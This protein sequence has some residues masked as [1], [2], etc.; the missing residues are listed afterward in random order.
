MS[1]KTDQFRRYGLIAALLLTLGATWWA[2]GSDD[3]PAVD[4][5]QASAGAR[6]AQEAR[7]GTARAPAQRTPAV[8]LAFTAP[9][10]QEAG[11]GRPQG[12]APPQAPF[13]WTPVQREPWADARE[14]QFAA[15]S[16]PPPP[17]PPVVAKGPPPPPPPPVAP[18]FPYQVM[19]RLVDGV[20]A[21]VFLVSANRSIAVK[22][23]DVVD[24][25]WRVENISEQGA[26]KLLWLPGRLTQTMALRASSP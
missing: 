3:E 23:G 8:S 14:A 12:D 15:W 7:P 18:P 9:D 1:Q 2:A 25:Q 21:Q 22:V 26:L 4:K 19:G 17:A 11:V 6:R 13:D 10:T 20:E 24:A 16:P 5:V